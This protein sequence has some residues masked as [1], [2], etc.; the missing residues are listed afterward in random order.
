MK[1]VY[2]AVMRRVHQ[3]QPVDRNVSNLAKS[4]ASGRTVPLAQIE[5]AGGESL[6]AM[7]AG[8]GD[9]HVPGA[10]QGDPLRREEL[11]I[12]AALRS[13][14]A[15]IEPTGSEPLDAVIARVGNVHVPGAVQSDPL[16]REE[17]AIIAARRS[18]LAEREP[19]GGESL[20]GQGR[21]CWLRR[22]RC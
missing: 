6:D 11:A 3:A 8:V 5:P 17:L 1:L 16:G 20:N 7:V 14:L 10:V 21:R 15:Q 9:V 19:A 4:A 12:T 22:R 13:P 18:P 2:T